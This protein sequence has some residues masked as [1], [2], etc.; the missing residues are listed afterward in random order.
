MIFSDCGINAVQNNLPCHHMRKPS[1][2]PA[3][4]LE[5]ESNAWAEG[6]IFRAWSAG[7]LDSM[8]FHL[9]QQSLFLTQQ[10]TLASTRGHVDTNKLNSNLQNYW[11]TP[12]THS[13]SPF[14]AQSRKL[15]KKNV[16]YKSQC[17]HMIL[18]LSIILTTSIKLL[19]R[20]Y[21]W[22]SRMRT[23]SGRLTKHLKRRCM[24]S[25]AP[26]FELQSF[27]SSPVLLWLKPQSKNRYL[28]E[29]IF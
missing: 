27:C 16:F 11:H 19:L 3:K 9:L 26:G 28:S 5:S 13:L 23:R 24:V 22:M 14:A 7:G 18:H 8:S 17:L 25:W 1:V 12:P 10:H 2:F 20:K 15:N 4:S 29:T 21:A 6:C